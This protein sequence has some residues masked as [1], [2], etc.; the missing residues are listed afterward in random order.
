MSRRRLVLAGGAVALS[1]VLTTGA[2]PLA[3]AGAADNRSEAT[4]DRAVAFL[5]A[6]QQPSGGF[7]GDTS[8]DGAF[9]G[10]ETVDA[11]VAIAEAAQT[12]LVYDGGAARR[13]VTAV[14]EDGRSGLDFLDDLAETDPGA[15]KL[16]E[17]AIAAV[18]VGLDP[19]RFDPQGDG[20]N[21]LVAEMVAKRSPDEFF[22]SDLL[23]LKALKLT[24]RLV[25]TAERDR[26]LDAQ[27]PDGGWNYE[28]VA[29]SDSAS[30]V[31]VTGLALE[32]LVAAG[33]DGASA[34]VD[35]AVDFLASQQN[36]DGGFHPSYEPTSNP[37]STRNAVLGLAAA[38]HDVVGGCWAARMA[39][40]PD[41]YLRGAQVT[42]GRIGPETDFSPTQYTSL[43]VQALV[44]SFQPIAR[45]DRQ[46][47]PTTGYRLVA[48]DGGVFAY[49]DATFEGSTGDLV[50][51][52]PVVAAAETPSGR[53]YWLFATD[54]GVFSF[55]D[56]PFLGSTGDVVLNQPIVAAAAT[57]SGGGY[58]L[59]AADGG[60]F[61]FGDAAFLGSM[62]GT[63]LNQP[64]VAGAS[65]P[66]GRGYWLFAADGGV[67]SFGDAGFHGSTG[68]IT[69]NQPIVGADASRSGRGYWLFAS[70][71]GV[72]ALGDADF[73]GSAG[74]SPLN[75][76]VVDGWR[77]EGDGYRLVASDGGVFTYGAPFL[78]S[79]GGQPLNS[80]I[81]TALP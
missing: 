45:A 39:P 49:G 52:R 6:Q 19:R 63:P 15:G 24:G 30:D 29:D 7:G 13:A 38:G 21:D 54:G 62:G 25:T 55:G 70:D 44:R 43:A 26:L 1:A 75:Q 12:T 48:A 28:G 23:I 50:L 73:Q 69:L 20:A 80:P 8:V 36:A 34:A 64:I 72:F 68:A 31:D 77:S 4:A 71:G 51:N 14:Q 67:F 81:V 76:P 65:T 58:W 41:V 10:S 46:A 35:R 32:V 18:A 11:V 74:G 37:G 17:I 16:A 2:L 53:G 3:P 33:A 56:A 78:G 61:S 60:V 47:C 59:F 22:Y 57:P 5:A 42:G 79:R 66:S 40:S 27:R 9:V